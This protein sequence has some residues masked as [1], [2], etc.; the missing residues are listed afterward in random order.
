MAQVIRLGPKVGSHLVLFCIH[1]V[2][3]VNSRNNSKSWWQHHN[4]II[5]TIS[6]IHH[7]IVSK[8]N[9]IIINHIT[10]SLI[11][12]HTLGVCLTGE[13]TFQNSHGS[14]Y[15]RSD[16]FRVT[17]STEGRQCSWVGTACGHNT[18]MMSR[19]HCNGYVGCLALR[20]P[21]KAAF[22]LWQCSWLIVCRQ[23]TV[24]VSSIIILTIKSYFYSCDFRC[25][26]GGIW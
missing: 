3:R 18:A 8:T 5:I 2:N 19:R 21:F 20:L 6:V 17:H 13:Q 16:V 10:T 26:G 1:H 7:S 23:Q 14:T 11:I 25:S 24:T 15:Y 4:I 22:F 9:S 12:T